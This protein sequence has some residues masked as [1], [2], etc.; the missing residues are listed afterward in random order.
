MV[1]HVLLTSLIYIKSG[2]GP[3]YFGKLIYFAKEVSN[4]LY[5]THQEA[6]IVMADINVGTCLET[7]EK[8]MV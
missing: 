6:T 7:Q 2:N 4:A 1:Y 3:L 5:Y 8:L